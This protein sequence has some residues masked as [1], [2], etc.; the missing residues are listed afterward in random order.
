MINISL[1][2]SKYWKSIPVDF[3]NTFS[4]N[5]ELYEKLDIQPRSTF[6]WYFDE[7]IKLGFNMNEK[8]YSFKGV[9]N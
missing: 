1:L 5:Y 8:N 4:A 3:R 7:K 6:P 9:T 2:N